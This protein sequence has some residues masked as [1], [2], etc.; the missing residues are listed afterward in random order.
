MAGNYCFWCWRHRRCWA[1]LWATTDVLFARSTYGFHFFNYRRRIRVIFLNGCGFIIFSAVD[2]SAFSTE[3]CPNLYQ[4]LLVLGSLLMI[5]FQA[6]INMGVVTGCLPT[7]GMSL[8]FISYG[9]SNLVLM[10]ILIGVILNCL[11]HWS[12][13]PLKEAREL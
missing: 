9:G 6:L 7:K 4:Y 11:C 8:P 1:W 5:E 2:F 12:K 13:V 10:F 3:V